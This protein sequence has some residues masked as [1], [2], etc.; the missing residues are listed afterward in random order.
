MPKKGVLFGVGLSSAALATLGIWGMYKLIDHGLGALFLL[1]L[2]SV[3]L[4][5]CL[6]YVAF[7]VRATK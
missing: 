2:I 3:L 7:S 1:I 4:S 6:A 5:V